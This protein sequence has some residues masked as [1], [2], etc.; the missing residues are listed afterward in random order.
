MCNWFALFFPATCMLCPF[1]CLGALVLFLLN[2]N[3]TSS[4]SMLHIDAEDVVGT[5]FDQIPVWCSC[6]LLCF[7]NH[8]ERCGFSMLSS[9]YGG[10]GF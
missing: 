7:H 8:S 10:F 9:I 6:T 4:D 5:L 1:C 2:V 3:R